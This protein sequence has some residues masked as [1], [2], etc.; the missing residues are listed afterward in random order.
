MLISNN[1]KKTYS[2]IV[3][4]SKKYCANTDRTRTLS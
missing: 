3:C 1:N 4:E 2:P